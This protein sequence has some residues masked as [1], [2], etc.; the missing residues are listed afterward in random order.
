[1]PD[2]TLL[3]IVAFLLVAVGLMGTV[4]P[5]LPGVPLVFLGLALAAWAEGFQ[6]VGAGTLSVLGLMA[7]LAYGIDLVAGAL[8]AKK[9][10]ASRL[11]VLGAA[12][13]TLAGLFLGLP[14]LVLGPFVGGAAG[15]LYAR[16]DLKQA[17]RAG[18]GAWLGLVVGG[19]TKLALTFSM[20][21]V[22]L[23]KRLL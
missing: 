23:A 13:G 14:G 21:A 22:F 19:A 12:L 11:A 3:L 18:F 17:G 7:L 15:E 2:P 4:L 6:Y 9:F 20:L 1:V 8:G 5:A 16:R 10:G